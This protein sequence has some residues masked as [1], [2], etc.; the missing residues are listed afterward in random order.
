MAAGDHVRTERSTAEELRQGIGLRLGD[1]QRESGLEGR[2]S[3]HAPAGNQHVNRSREPIGESLSLPKRQVQHIAD[4]RALINVV[5]EERVFSIQ[6][7][8]VLNRAFAAGGALRRWLGFQEAV[9]SVCIRKILRP[10]V[11]GR[12]RAAR[13]EALDQ[14]CL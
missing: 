10:R 6:V 9:E 8:V 12:Q 5:A 4:H 3:A 13:T 1:E 11:V 2:D 7:V 14:L